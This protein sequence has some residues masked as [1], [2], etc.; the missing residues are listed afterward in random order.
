MYE[1][2]ATGRR[3]RTILSLFEILRGD[4]EPLE[5]KCNKGGN[6]KS[7][8]F[9]TSKNETES[10][11]GHD[12]FSTN[13]D[14]SKPRV[15]K[16]NS[17]KKQV[18]KESA[19]ATVDKKSTTQLESTTSIGEEVT[20]FAEKFFK[21]T[22]PTGKTSRSKKIADKSS[23]TTKSPNK[24]SKTTE[25]SDKSSKTTESSNKSSKTT[26]SSNKSSKTTESS[27]KSSKTT[28]LA[29]EASKTKEPADQSSNTTES[30]GKSKKKSVPVSK[31]K[32]CLHVDASAPQIFTP[33]GRITMIPVTEE[34]K[35]MHANALQVLDQVKYFFFIIHYLTLHSHSNK[36]LKFLHCTVKQCQYNIYS[37][38]LGSIISV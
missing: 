25:S 7:V 38:N 4:R 20:S 22:K 30:V 23:K 18:A 12:D 29:D 34:E 5:I 11:E 37:L 15:D 19:P 16:R 31:P 14:I 3:C 1:E 10:S 6:K 17:D 33:A 26:E 9:E 32:K 8:H 36:N 35:E 21:V 28:E 24:S 27:N 13:D 2:K